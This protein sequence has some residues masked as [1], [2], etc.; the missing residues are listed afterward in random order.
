[1]AHGRHYAFTQKRQL[2]EPTASNSLKLEPYCQQQKCNPMSVVLAIYGLWGTTRAI[3]AA[4]EL[5]IF[6]WGIS[7]ALTDCGMRPRSRFVIGT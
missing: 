1:M 2:S 3:S 4:A 7:T 6:L 5:L